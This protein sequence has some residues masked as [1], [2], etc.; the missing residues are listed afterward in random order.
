MITKHFLTFIFIT[1]VSETSYGANKK[2][3]RNISKSQKIGEGG[4]EEHISF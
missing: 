1:T 4:D 3:N 2:N